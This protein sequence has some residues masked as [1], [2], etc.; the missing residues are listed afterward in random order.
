MSPRYFLWP[1]T[2]GGIAA[3]AILA[4]GPLAA[5]TSFTAT[6]ALPTVTAQATGAAITIERTPLVTATPNPT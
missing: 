2:A 4:A 3:L 5:A 1:V 6:P